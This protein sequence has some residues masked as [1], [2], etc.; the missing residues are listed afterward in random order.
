MGTYIWRIDR[1]ADFMHNVYRW[2]NRGE[3][4]CT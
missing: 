3:G 1:R 4:D 2:Y